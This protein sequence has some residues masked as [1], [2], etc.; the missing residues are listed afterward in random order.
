M[1]VI[2][3]LDKFRATATADELAA[4]VG[5]AA[6]AAGWECVAR[7]L[8][9]GGE[10]TLDVLGGANRTTEVTD[11]LGRPV[12]A[13]W[14]LDE[15]GAVLEAAA[16]N[17]LA[18]VG[19]AEGNDPVGA[20]SRGVGELLVAAVRAGARHLILGVGG[21][22]TSDGGAGAVA[23]WR[24]AMG[25]RPLSMLQVC[26]DVSTRFTDAAIVYGPQKGASPAQ[27]E[28]LTERLQRLRD[29][30]WEQGG[31]DLD[32]VPGSGAA[33]G[34][35]GG[36]AAVGATL[37]PGLDA[38]ADRVGFDKAMTEADLV[39][40]GEG[41]FDATSLQGKVVGGVIDR[42]RAL[43]VPVLVVAGSV[44]PGVRPGPGVDVIELVG[45]FGVDRSFGDA[46]GCVREAV[47]GVLAG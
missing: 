17:G 13:S 46:V 12:T 3:A 27:I 29:E 10:G 5:Q 20:T 30:T 26:C 45:R 33:G 21:S 25:D 18:L 9:D 15:E 44:A 7:P 8:A 1:R 42:A 2:A 40:T 38:I 31:V 36:L 6:A 32:Q 19:G 22:A 41:R 4:A 43:G 34:L 14:R 35:A 24:E 23:A 47:Q 37:V 11:P 16:A 28:V 39:V